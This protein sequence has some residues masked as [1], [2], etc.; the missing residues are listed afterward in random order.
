MRVFAAPP[1]PREE[2]GPATTT[3]AKATSEGEA[4]PPPER[5]L[6]LAAEAKPS[7]PCEVNCVRWRPRRSR[8]EPSVLAAACD[9]GVVRLFK[10]VNE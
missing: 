9:D 10:L 5:L 2:E 6:E 8:R 7:P 4:S 1:P 3:E